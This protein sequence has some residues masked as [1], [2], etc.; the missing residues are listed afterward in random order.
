M[1]PHM[2]RLVPHLTSNATIR[3]LRISVPLIADLVD[4]ARYF[5]PSDLPAPAGD[6]LRPVLRPRLRR[7]PFRWSPNRDP[8][9]S[10]DDGNTGGAGVDLAI[11]GGSRPTALA[12]YLAQREPAGGSQRPGG[13]AAPLALI[14][15]R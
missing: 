2:V 1:Q 14:D 4:N 5:L 6:E 13:E 7:T 12:Q 8:A 3:H 15:Q 10:K 9:L 11:E